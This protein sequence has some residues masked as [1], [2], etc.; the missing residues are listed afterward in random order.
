MNAPFDL[1]IGDRIDVQ[2]IAYNYYGESAYS[3]IASNLVVV[4]KPEAILNLRDDTAQ[5]SAT[6]IALLWDPPAIDNGRP[7]L[8]YTIE[9]DQGS[10]LNDWI[11]LELNVPGPEYVSVL[12]M[13]SGETYKLRVYARNSVGLS[14]YREI[15]ILVA[16]VPDKPN[17]P[18]SEFQ[19]PFVVLD[20]EAPYD[21][22]TTITS[23]T[24][25]I[26]AT[27]GVTYHQELSYCDGTNAQVIADTECTIPLS[28]LR[29]APFNLVWG[30]SV[31]LKVFATNVKGDSE[32]SDV[33]TG[34]II[35]RVPDAPIL[36]QNEP[37]ITLGE[38]IGL[39]WQ[40]G[41]EP[42]GTEILDYQLNF[43]QGSSNFVVYTSGL[44]ET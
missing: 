6:Q 17:T 2:M 27:D 34:A 10:A 8:D 37:D 42:G 36:L 3:P 23:Y 24:I 4:W 30:Q 12:G 20:W 9:Y 26:E 35:L 11:T 39:T 25:L 19:D 33:G 15:T 21:G 22:H 14:P 1:P 16:Q 5:T 38:Q 18:T 44:L 7:V 41:A 13:V 31:D 28:I 29:G 43:D 40:A 32:I